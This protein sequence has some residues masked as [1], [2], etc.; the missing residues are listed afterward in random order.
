MFWQNT[1][2][3]HHRVR[4]VSFWSTLFGGGSDNAASSQSKDQPVRKIQATPK[5]IVSTE[6]YKEKYG[7]I[8]FQE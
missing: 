1:F 3:N 6:S 2:A 4:V 8:M 7:I 5:Q